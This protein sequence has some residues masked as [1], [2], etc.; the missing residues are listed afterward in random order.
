MKGDAEG[1]ADGNSLAHAAREA[2]DARLRAALAAVGLDVEEAAAAVEVVRAELAQV[3]GATATCPAGTMADGDR[4]PALADIIPQLVW[5]SADYG[6]WVWAS[7]S[8][9]AYTGQSQT[10]SLGQGWLEPIHP[11]DREATRR[12][13]DE[14]PKLGRL[15]VD[16]RIRRA[17]DGTWR[18]HH[19][20]SA[21]LSWSG[22][23]HEGD[24]HAREW[25]GSS[26]D[27]EDLRRMEG[28]QRALL[29]E[30]QHRTRN[31]LAVVAAIARRSLP[32]NLERDDFGA[33]LA[34][35]GRVQG[36]L[37]RS[38]AWSVPLRD[39]IEAE[40][41]AF[42]DGDAERAEVN[43]PR[44]ELPGPVVQPIALVLHELATN[45]A[46]HG[47]IAQLSGHLAVTWRLEEAAEGAIRLIIEWRES[48]V[49]LPAG[50]LA[51]HFGREVIERTVPHQ[52]RGEARLER[53]AD[54]VCCK[55]ALPLSRQETQV[56]A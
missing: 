55:L 40:L 33:R 54:G 9:L 2:E 25:V 29:L 44:V 31:I 15:E 51:K 22:V 46:K 27:I 39:L 26:A 20:R 53:G 11:E 19:T 45:A 8:W 34:C 17:L 6:Q 18:L 12:A 3:P 41:Q 14:A 42:G 37:A 23:P 47:A 56:A 38:S 5:R 21:P 43:G 1:I 13:W 7:P 48:G 49:T 35:L 4:L 36:F 30:V 32:P 10:E 50:P 28:E 16:H 24:R 52:L